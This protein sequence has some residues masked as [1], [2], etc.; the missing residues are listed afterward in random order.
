[1]L[2]NATNPNFDKASSILSSY[3]EPIH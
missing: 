2:I 3:M 1:M